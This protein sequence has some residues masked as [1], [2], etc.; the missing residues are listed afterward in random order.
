VLDACASPG[1]KAVLTA[2]TMGTGHLVALDLPGKREERLRENL[3]K[4]SGVKVSIVTGNLLRGARARIESAGAPTEYPAVMLDVPCSNNGVMRHRVDV[5]WRLS[6]GDFSRHAAQQLA[7]VE[8]ASSFVAPGGRIVYSTCSIDPEENTGV[9]D[10][11]LEKSEGRFA[12]EKSV[13]SVPWESG[14]DGAAAFLLC[15]VT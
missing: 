5:K 6:P 15:R 10:A 9:V 2:D 11:F 1:G 4:V 12:L 3:A 8:S 14:H 13:I 7:L